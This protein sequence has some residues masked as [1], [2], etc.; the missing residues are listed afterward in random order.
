M[1]II[2]YLMNPASMFFRTVFYPS[3]L[4]DGTL[5]PHIQEQMEGYGPKGPLDIP[6]DGPVGDFPAGF[7]E[8]HKDVA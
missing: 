5:P 4:G 7:G 2:D 6:K 8:T 3:R 1:A